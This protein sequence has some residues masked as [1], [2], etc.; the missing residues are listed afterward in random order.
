MLVRVSQVPDIVSIWLTSEVYGANYI[1]EYRPDRVLLDLGI[2]N[3]GVL[4]EM[5]INE[6]SG[7]SPLS[8]KKGKK[9]FV[10]PVSIWGD[11][12]GVS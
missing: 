8:F 11:L 3:Y 6:I 7:V 4:D 9:L 1:S 2:S 5:L 12:R 10:P